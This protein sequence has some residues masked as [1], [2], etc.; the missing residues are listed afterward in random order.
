MDRFNARILGGAN[1]ASRPAVSRPQG[2]VV[3]GWSS[4]RHVADAGPASAPEAFVRPMVHELYYSRMTFP[5][6]LSL[7]RGGEPLG[8]N[9][10]K[11]AYRPFRLNPVPKSEAGL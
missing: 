3:H 11:R 7:S 6:H 5:D 9:A 1:A 2:R 8:R 4:R 10:Q